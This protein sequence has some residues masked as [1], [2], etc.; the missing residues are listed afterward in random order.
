[1]KHK[2]DKNRIIASVGTSNIN[3]QMLETHAKLTYLYPYG[4]SPKKKRTPIQKRRKGNTIYNPHIRPQR[5]KSEEQRVKI[6]KSKNCQKKGR[7]WG[8]RKKENKIEP[9]RR[10]I[11]QSPFSINKMKKKINRRELE[12]RTTKEIG[13]LMKDMGQKKKAIP[14]HGQQEVKKKRKCPVGYKVRTIQKTGIV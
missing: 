14:E 7:N 9:M 2:R 8:G 11:T 13:S 12:T 1:M 4:P 6:K 3:F 10:I 5:D